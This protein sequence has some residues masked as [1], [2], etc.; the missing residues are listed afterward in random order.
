LSATDDQ[1]GGA[2]VSTASR[3]GSASCVVIAICLIVI[4][5]LA[6]L[7]FNLGPLSPEAAFFPKIILALAGF[8]AA[9]KLVSLLSPRASRLI[10]PELYADRSLPSLEEADDALVEEDRGVPVWAAWSWLALTMAAIVLLGV[11]VGS[12]IAC[13]V[14]IFFS[15]RGS[16]IPALVTSGATTLFLYLVFER[17]MRIDL[18]SGV[19][20]LF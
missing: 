7:V 16:L 17:F 14:Y 18:G 2:A 19:L 9:L 20:G 10:E 13:F 3:S 12:G 5:Y 4:G 1:A 8:L 11:L 15:A 6:V